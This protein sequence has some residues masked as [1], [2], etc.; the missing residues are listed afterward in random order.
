VRVLR[1]ESLV[2]LAVL[3]GWNLTWA[4]VVL[5]RWGLIPADAAARTLLAAEVFF[6]RDP[7]L[8]NLGFVWLP[9]PALLQLPLV[10]IPGLWPTGLAGATVSALAGA[11]AG[12]L[13]N[14][15]ARAL[16]WSRSR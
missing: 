12:A 3:F 16:G 10:L 6:S 1:R 8:S 9:L 2:L 13:I 5:V 15:I 4:W 14:N 7:K 11:V